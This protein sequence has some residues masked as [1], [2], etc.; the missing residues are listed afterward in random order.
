M[1]KTV[2]FFEIL[3]ALSLLVVPALAQT[4]VDTVYVSDT[5][6]VAS[7]SNLRTFKIPI[8]LA[9]S[10]A[11]GGFNFVLTTSDPTILMPVG[12]DTIGSRLCFHTD[13]TDSLGI[14]HID[15]LL[16]WEYF[17]AN[18]GVEFPESLFIAAIA[19]HPSNPINT[20]P[21]ESGR[22]KIFNVEFQIPCTY[23]RPNLGDTTVELRVEVANISDPVGQLHPVVYYNSVI[24]IQM[25]TT[26]RGDANC[27]G[28]RV[29]S[30]VSRLVA[31]FKGQSI[32]PCSLNAGDVNNDGQIRGSDVTY[33]V[34]YFKG[35]GPEP[36]PY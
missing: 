29:G 30:D 2:V 15:T 18:R 16:P 34:R 35:L 8:V 5:T 27:N 13:T 28:V 19:N 32:C 26:I 36:P 6:I 4:C 7:V 9:N 31:F 10:C 22:G 20:P 33:L 25:G 23:M 1:K 12:A 24:T 14:P 11:V 17:Q 3:I 21:L